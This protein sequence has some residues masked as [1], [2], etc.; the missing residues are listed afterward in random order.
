MAMKIGTDAFK[1]RV[2]QGIDNE[3]MKALFRVHRSVCGRG[4]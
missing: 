2:S 1:E 4:A 3:F